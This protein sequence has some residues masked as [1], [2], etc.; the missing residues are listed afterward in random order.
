[1]TRG[2]SLIEMLVVLAIL[3]I[4]VSIMLVNGSDSREYARDA[5]RLSDIQTLQVKVQQYYNNNSVYPDDLN[6]LVED[7]YISEIPSDPLE[8]S[9]HDYI[10][11]RNDPDE[12]PGFKIISTPLE[13]RTVEPD[14][15]YD[16]CPISACPSG[17]DHTLPSEVDEDEVYGVYSSAGKCL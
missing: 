8:S 13:G 3:G 11:L 5:E 4:L 12:F 1:M 17:C 2:F 16:A 14:S 6:K 9:T 10:Y 15:T 7:D